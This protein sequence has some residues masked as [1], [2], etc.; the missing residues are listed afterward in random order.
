MEPVH[1]RPDDIWMAFG[2]APHSPGP[3]VPAEGLAP[4]DLLPGQAAD[5]T[6]V[7][8]WAGEPHAIFLQ[9]RGTLR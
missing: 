4:F 9:E 7:W 2:Y 3:R 5:V 8:A 6:V 1:I